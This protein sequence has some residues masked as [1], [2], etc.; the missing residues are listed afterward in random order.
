M[1]L[2][3]IIRWQLGRALEV[4]LLLDRCLY[5]EEQ[6]FRVQIEQ[7]FQETLSP[8]NIGILAISKNK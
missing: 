2:C 1:W 8:R 5:L 3:N 7:Y 6:G 4:Y